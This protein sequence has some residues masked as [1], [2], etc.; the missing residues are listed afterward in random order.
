MMKNYW[1]ICES[2]SNNLISAPFVASPMDSVID[3]RMACCISKYGLIPIF[4]I[5]KNNNQRVF[6]DIKSLY[7]KKTENLVFLSQHP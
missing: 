7:Q 3:Y 5:G 2:G 4:C 1:S 6:E